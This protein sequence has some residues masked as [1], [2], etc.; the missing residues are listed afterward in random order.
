[1]GND[2]ELPKQP[3]GWLRSSHEEAVLEKQVLKPDGLMP[4]RVYSH[5]VEVTGGTT[6]YVASQVGMD[7][8]W[9]IVG[10]GLDAQAVKAFENP[11]TAL[12]AAAAR[13]PPIS[14]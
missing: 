7:A 2:V 11:K 14:S 4:N 3:G 5:V 1:M 12:A 10:D 13:H 8:D 9:Q 6:V